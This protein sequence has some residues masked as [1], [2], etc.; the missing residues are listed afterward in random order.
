MVAKEATATELAAEVSKKVAEKE[1]D[2]KELA[3]PVKEVD[4]K[5][6]EEERETKGRPYQ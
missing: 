1:I 4:T 6:E 2:T 5:D 3:A